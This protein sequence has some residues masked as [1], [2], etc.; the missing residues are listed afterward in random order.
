MSH[1]EQR[2]TAAVG[3]GL[4]GRGLSGRG[5]SGRGLSGRGAGRSSGSAAS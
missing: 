5:L 2:A 1:G 4:S 3:P